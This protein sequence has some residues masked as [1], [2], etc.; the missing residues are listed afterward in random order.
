MD[1]EDVTSWS[2]TLEAGFLIL[3]CHCHC[4]STTMCYYTY[5]LTAKRLAHQAQPLAFRPP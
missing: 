3:K 2:G 5:L 4:S 1:L